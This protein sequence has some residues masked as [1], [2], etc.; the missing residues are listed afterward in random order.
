MRL[1]LFGRRGHPNSPHPPTTLWPQSRYLGMQS[2]NLCALHSSRPSWRG[3][4]TTNSS[5]TS[6]KRFSLMT[7]TATDI[8][9]E[10]M[11]VTLCAPL[12]DHTWS[13]RPLPGLTTCGLPPPCVEILTRGTPIKNASRS[14][15]PDLLLSWRGILTLRYRFLLLGFAA[16]R[17]VPPLGLALNSRT[18]VPSSLGA[19]LLTLTVQVWPPHAIRS[20]SDGRLV[21]CGHARSTFPVWN[22][23]KPSP[24]PHRGIC[25]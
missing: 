21:T 8:S 25:L 6:R 14:P 15:R 17:I 7:H 9:Y 22:V 3:M 20:P 19:A 11:E 4:M 13:P 18:P 23:L 5:M 10:E 1:I 12:P 2:C 24:D 16:L